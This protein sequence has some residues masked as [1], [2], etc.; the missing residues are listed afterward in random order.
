MQEVGSNPHQTAR[1]LLDQMLGKRLTSISRRILHDPDETACAFEWLTGFDLRFGR[2][3]IY[4]DVD[5][6][7][8]TLLISRSPRHDDD[9]TFII[10][11]SSHPLWKP[12][13]GKPLTFAWTMVNSR[14]YLDG[15]A[16][17]F[18]TYAPSATLVAAGSQIHEFSNHDRDRRVAEAASTTTEQDITQAV[19]A[20]V[21]N[22]V[23]IANKAANRAAHEASK[24]AHGRGRSGRLT[25]APRGLTGGPART[26]SAAE[27]TKL[28]DQAQ[29]Y[30]K[31]NPGC[32]VDQ[33]TKALDTTN[34]P[35][36]RAMIQELQR[37]GTVTRPK[38]R[39][40]KSNPTR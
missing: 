3:V 17:A 2:H 23:Y 32:R 6:D 4:I 22:L 20:L 25:I 24:N 30:I 13:L 15:L 26:R 8:D 14:G 36:L 38:A 9:D 16:F 35:A 21:S 5:P 11:G 34:T 10:D 31:D 37:A 39:A 18:E 19:D 7:D 28:R 1:E 33:I 40:A 29:A 27:L 12:I